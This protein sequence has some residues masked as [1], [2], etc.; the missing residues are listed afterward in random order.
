MLLVQTDSRL[1]AIFRF[2]KKPKEL[3]VIFPVPAGVVHV[4][5]TFVLNLTRN[6][7]ERRESIGRWRRLGTELFLFWQTQRANAGK[8]FNPRQ[9]EPGGSRDRAE[10]MTVADKIDQQ[11]GDDKDRDCS[12]LLGKRTLKT[13]Q[14]DGQNSYAE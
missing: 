3:A 5:E 1:R 4:H 9:K 13:A 11:V 2:V 7:V 14:R 10:D 8:N 6:F 12:R